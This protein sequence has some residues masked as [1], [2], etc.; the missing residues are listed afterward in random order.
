MCLPHNKNSVNVIIYVLLSKTIEKAPPIL[1]GWNFR[2]TLVSGM[3][4]SGHSG[5]V[6]PGAPWRDSVTHGRHVPGN[7]AHPAPFI[8]LTTIS[9]GQHT[10]RRGSP[11]LGCVLHPS[12]GFVYFLSCVLSP[13]LLRITCSP[14]SASL[15]KLLTVI[16][17]CLES[18]AAPL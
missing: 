4:S 7:P 10:A 16:S 9:Q 15:P 17:H 1:T 18:T 6:T 13:N 5:Q 11:C 12:P 8:Q 3:R 2:V 14:S